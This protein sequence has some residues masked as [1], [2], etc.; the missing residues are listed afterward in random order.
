MKVTLACL[1]WG[2]TK[3][4]PTFAR[5]FA[6]GV[7][8]QRLGRSSEM[9][10]WMK[11]Q[12]RN[13]TIEI[14]HNHSL[15]MMPNV[16]PGRIANHFGIPYVVSPRGTL[17]D[18]PFHHGSRVKR[19]FW[20][21]VQKPSL[22]GVTCW[23][24][25]SHSEY[26]DIRR[27]GFRQ[28]VAVIPNGIDIPPAMAKR[29]DGPRTLMYLGRLHP[30]KGLDWLLRAWSVTENKFPEWRLHIVGADKQGYLAEL[31]NLAQSLALKRVQFNDALY[32][33]QKWKAYS[34]ADLFVLPT[35]NENFGMVVAEAL[36]SGTPAIVSKGA[37][38]SGLGTRQA[39]WWIDTGVDPLISC[40]EKAL[41]STPEDL[42]AMGQRGRAW[43]EREFSWD[44]VG[45]R[46][47]KSYNWVLGHEPLPDWVISD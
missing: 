37:P 14:I 16:Y 33:E 15:W 19:L 28:P 25:T 13:R 47:V 20:P 3:Q 5:S 39:G 26:E 8:P 46:M 17:G 12:A 32:G 9:W 11:K 7:Y 45:E 41:S 36:A 18:W 4:L 38:W 31:R 42:A 44:L 35:R 2:P 24:A 30:K 1:D 23:H 21:L 27:M 34:E 29:S 40:L 22:K 6:M 10:R 43:M